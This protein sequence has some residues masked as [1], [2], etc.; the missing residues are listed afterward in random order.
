MRTTYLV[1]FACSLFVGCAAK[2]E[3]VTP[4]LEVKKQPVTFFP[5]T[6]F[7]KGQIFVLDSLPITPL[8][9]TTQKGKVDSLW[10][11]AGKTKPYL[12]PFL[13]PTITE[14]NFLDLF[15]E[16]R[17][18]DQTINAITF[19]YD[20]SVTLPDSLSL[21]HWDVYVDPEK[22]TVSKVYILKEFIKDGENITQQ[23]TWQTG[24]YAKI[25][26]IVTRAG[27]AEL[28]KEELITWDF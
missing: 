1:I 18:N 6:T 8:L 28:L 19:T 21:R 12:Q 23:L 16:T 2:Q 5:V 3:P 14:T 15:R 25:A 13:E 7:I 9:I 20:P 26:T 10:L 24:K 17:F 4:E 11:P 27:Q 22:S